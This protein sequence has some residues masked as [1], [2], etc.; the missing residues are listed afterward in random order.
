VRG[1]VLGCETFPQVE[2]AMRIFLAWHGRLARTRPRVAD[3]AP[4]LTTALQMG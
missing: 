4:A 3:L 2:R 1:V